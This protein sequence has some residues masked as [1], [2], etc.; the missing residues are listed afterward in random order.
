MAVFPKID[1]HGVTFAKL[2]AQPMAARSHPGP[3]TA[4]GIATQVTAA[5]RERSPE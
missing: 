4:R 1:R 5:G 3:T 2:N